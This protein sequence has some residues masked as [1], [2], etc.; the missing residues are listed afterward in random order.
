MRKHCLQLFVSSQSLHVCGEYLVKVKEEHHKRKEW[1][2]FRIKQEAK[3]MRPHEPIMKDTSEVL[4]D[5]DVPDVVVERV[6]GIVTARRE[7]QNLK[8][9]P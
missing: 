1:I 7:K 6:H 8:K 2:I 9:R 5:G 4:Q 3:K